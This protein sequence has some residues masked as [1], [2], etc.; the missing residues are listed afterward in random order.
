MLLRLPC[1]FGKHLRILRIGIA[2]FLCLFDKADD[3]VFMK[4]TV[5]QLNINLYVGCKG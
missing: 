1:W 5:L 3:D 2:F 4:L